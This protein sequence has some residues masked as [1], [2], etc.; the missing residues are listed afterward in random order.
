MLKYLITII[1]L[2]FFNNSFSQRG[3]ELPWVSGEIVSDSCYINIKHTITSITKYKFNKHPLLQARL[4]IENNLLKADSIFN[5]S[6]NS[7]EIYY[8]NRQGGLIQIES[9]GVHGKIK[10]GGTKVFDN[11]NNLIFWEHI[12]D[13]NTTMRIRRGYDDFNHLIFE[14]TYFK[15]VGRAKLTIS[16]VGAKSFEYTKGVCNCDF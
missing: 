7:K 12:Y 1:F 2:L 4:Q 5:D 16:S 14:C 15:E 3:K 8:Y 9:I 10:F 13:S 11:Q 6:T